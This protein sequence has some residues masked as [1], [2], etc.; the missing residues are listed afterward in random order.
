MHRDKFGLV[1]SI[2]DFVLIPYND[3]LIVGKVHTFLNLRVQ[4][5]TVRRG[6]VL[7]LTHNVIK[8]DTIQNL[9][10]TDYPELLI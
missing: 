10:K 5:D 9:L 2:G 6:R 4:T 1:L 3:E 8:F 7:L